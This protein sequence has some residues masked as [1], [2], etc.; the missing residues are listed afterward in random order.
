MRTFCWATPAVLWANTIRAVKASCRS[1][2]DRQGAES[3]KESVPFTVYGDRLGDLMQ[4]CPGRNR[5]FTA[6]QT[7]RMLIA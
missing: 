6:I 3:A 7:A 2:E 1:N 5:T 4:S